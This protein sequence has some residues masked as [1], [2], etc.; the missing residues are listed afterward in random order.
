MLLQVVEVLQHVAGTLYAFHLKSFEEVH[1]LEQTTAFCG[2]RAGEL[3]IGAQDLHAACTVPVAREIIASIAS[4]N[5]RELDVTADATAASDAS[6]ALAGVVSTPA[7]AEAEQQ[8]Q[9][10]ATNFREVQQL[11]S[12]VLLLLVLLL[13]LLPPPLLQVLLL[14]NLLFVILFLFVVTS[15]LFE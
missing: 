3:G 12:L 9:M 11:L 5:F 7:S 13:L 14:L 15:G 6:D 10:P 8:Q 4:G 1:V 2:A